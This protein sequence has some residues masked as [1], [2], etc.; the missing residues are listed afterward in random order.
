VMLNIY[1]MQVIFERSDRDRSG[2]IDAFELRDALLSLG[3]LWAVM[4]NIYI[5]LT[6]LWLCCE[7]WDAMG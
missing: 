7:E 4:L 2:K 5:M 1:I 6:T 3:M